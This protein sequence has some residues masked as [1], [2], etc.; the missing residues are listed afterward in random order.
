MVYTYKFYKN[1]FSLDLSASPTT[2]PMLWN[3]IYFINN[4]TYL[5]YN[6]QKSNKNN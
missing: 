6:I 1:K 3:V 2:G 5:K 4:T